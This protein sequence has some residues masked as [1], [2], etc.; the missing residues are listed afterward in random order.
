M[1]K[2]LRYLE[3]LI[4]KAL[5]ALPAATPERTEAGCLHIKWDAPCPEIQ[6]L[7]LTILHNEVVLSCGITHTHYS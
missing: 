3:R 4:T 1:H 7:W 2:P 5:P 6:A